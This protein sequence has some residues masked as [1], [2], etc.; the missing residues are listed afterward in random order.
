MKRN[1]LMQECRE[2]IT[3]EI[4]ED[5]DFNIDVV[6]RIFDLL[7]ERNLSQRAFA[8]QLGKNEAEISRW[9][10][11]THNFTLKTIRLIEKELDAPVLKV[12]KHKKTFSTITTQSVNQNKSIIV[13][14]AAKYLFAEQELLFLIASLTFEFPEFDEIFDLNDGEIMEKITVIP[15]LMNIAI[16]TL[17]GIVATKT[18]GTF[19]RNFP[20]PLIDPNTLLK[21]LN[22]KE[23]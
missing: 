14:I 22:P 13:E 16:G 11:G 17:R 6:N 8:K 5:I 9:M 15:T 21:K 3:P 19:L 4:K 18:S 10:Q 20:L 23:N 12:V 7:E 2:F 1:S